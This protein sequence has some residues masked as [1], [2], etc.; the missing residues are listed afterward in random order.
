MTQ[1]KFPWALMV[2]T[3]MFVV[4]AVS[5]SSPP[6]IVVLGIVAALI[7]GAGAVYQVIPRREDTG[8]VDPEFDQDRPGDPGAA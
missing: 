2:I 7:S 5:P 6:W 3:A 1:P 8:E 4:V